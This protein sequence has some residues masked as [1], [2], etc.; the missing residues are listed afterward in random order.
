MS[1]VIHDFFSNAD[2]II[3]VGGLLLVLLMIY[4]E[5]AV[6]LGMVLPGGD[7]MLFATGIFCGSN[8]FDLP[9]ILIIILIVVAS[10]SGDTTGYYQGR[11]VGQRLFL[12]ENSRFFKSEYLVRSNQFYEKYRAWAFIMGRF[13][14]I[15]RTFLPILAGA[16]GIHFKRFLLYDTMGAII[17]VSCIVSIG[18][19]FGKEFPEVIDYSV[20]ILLGIVIIASLLILKLVAHKK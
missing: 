9:L 10:I 8:F 15:I 16:S 13:I 11:W 4:L 17:W 5:T 6:F 2:E 1:E 12:R 18:Y 7:Y 3:K 19:F 14:P 20:Y